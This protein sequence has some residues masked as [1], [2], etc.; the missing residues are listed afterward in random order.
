MATMQIWP[1][2]S[3]SLVTATVC[4]SHPQIVLTGFVNCRYADNVLDTVAFSNT[5]FL[6]V[7]VVVHTYLPSVIGMGINWGEDDD[8]DLLQLINVCL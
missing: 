7:P 4:F 1:I 8:L 2:I 6:I 5:Q 3:P